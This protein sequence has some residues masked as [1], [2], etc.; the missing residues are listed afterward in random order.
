MEVATTRPPFAPNIVKDQVAAMHAAPEDEG[1]A[2]TVPQ[3][4]EEH[5]DQ[6]IGQAARLTF[7]AAT[8]GDVEIVTQEAR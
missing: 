4:A 6:Q 8:Q 1:P 7:A 3:A 2:G 5:G